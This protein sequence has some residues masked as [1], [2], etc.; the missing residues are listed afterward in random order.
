VLLLSES[1]QTAVRDSGCRFQLVC[2][3]L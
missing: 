1:A 3:Y 2:T